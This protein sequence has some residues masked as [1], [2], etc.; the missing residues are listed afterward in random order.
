MKILVTFLALLLF[1]PGF[2]RAQEFDDWGEL[3]VLGLGEIYSL[4]Y[5]PDGSKLGVG[6]SGGVRHLDTDSCHIDTQM[7]GAGSVAS[8]SWSPDGK[9]IVSGTWDGP[10]K[11][12]DAENR[13][14]VKNT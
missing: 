10:V 1:Y 4:E 9:R 13:S 3:R 5:S 6:G 12:W 2:A 7:N 14:R 8:L 11:V